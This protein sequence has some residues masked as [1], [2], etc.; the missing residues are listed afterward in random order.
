GY[1]MA[2]GR[3]PVIGTILL[4]AGMGLASVVKAYVILPFGAA[5]GV[6]FFLDGARPEPFR[7]LRQIRPVPLLVGVGIAVGT[8]VAIGELFPRFNPSGLAEEAADLQ[9]AVHKTAGGSNYTIGD[10][11]ERSFAGQ[12]AFA[13]FAVLTALFRPVVFEVRNPQMG[14]SALETTVALWLLVK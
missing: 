1:A 10:P 5:A 7:R 13:P 2:T 8:I 3:R 14:L 4:G 9:G 12:L 11:A 6:W